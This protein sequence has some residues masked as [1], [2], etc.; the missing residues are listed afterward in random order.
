MTMDQL[1]TT[2][3]QV[4]KRLLR[5]ERQSTVLLCVLVFPHVAGGLLA[6]ADGCFI[7]HVC[8]SA[9]SML[10]LGMESQI[11]LPMRTQVCSQ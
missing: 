3:F 9:S 6:T 7:R 10:L 1:E 5:S 4:G 11:D 8:L 2:P